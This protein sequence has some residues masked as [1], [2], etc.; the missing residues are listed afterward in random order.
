M[1]FDLIIKRIAIATFAVSAVVCG[2]ALSADV[3]LREKVTPVK[4]VI[5]LGDIADIQNVDKAEQQRLALMPLWVAPPVGEKRYVTTNQVREV[6]K[7]R[8]FDATDLK[9]Y[10]APRVAIGWDNQPRLEPTPSVA[11]Q[12]EPSPVASNSMGFRVPPTTTLG[13]A[14]QP[15]KRDPMFLSGEQQDQLADQVREAIVRYLEDQ[16]G[17]IG[18]VDVEFDLSRRHG[19]LLSA[20]QS[21]ILVSGGRSPWFGRQSLEISFVGEKG[22]LE[23]PLSVTAYDLTPVLVAKRSL[24]KG[25]LISAADVAIE[26][27]PRDARVASNHTMVYSLEGALGHEAARA[28]REGDVVTAEM[29]LPPQM[30]TRNEIVELVSA[31]GGIIIRRQ[32]KALTDA[33]QGEITEVEL[34]NSKER[35]VARVVGPGK[36]ATMGSTLTTL[37]SRQP[38]PPAGYR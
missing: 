10:G 32:A 38:L 21:E 37:R 1:N 34:P 20:Q 19:E 36:L 22:P 15:V 4:S 24:A 25:Q 30:I 5:S 11:P 18:L 23:L 14:P 33:R 9:V 31:S 3:V 8:G 35:L 13:P 27:P 26:S 2:P 6:L 29:C 16:S 17:K 7:S 12:P 28:I